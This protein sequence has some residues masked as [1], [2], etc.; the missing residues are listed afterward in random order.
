MVSP[1]DAEIYINRGTD[2]R[3][4]R[5]RYTPTEEQIFAS[6]GTDIR[7]QRN[8]YSPTDKQIHSKSKVQVQQIYRLNM[9]TYTHFFLLSFFF[10]PFSFFLFFFVATNIF[11]TCLYTNTYN[12]TI[13]R[14]LFLFSNHNLFFFDMKRTFGDKH[15]VHVTLRFGH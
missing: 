1:T 2:I 11:S 6:R 8:S 7:Q 13:T 5:N 3:Q 12:H 15:Y 10:F 9:F 14:F 4:Q